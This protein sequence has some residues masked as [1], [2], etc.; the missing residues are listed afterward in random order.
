MNDRVDR[1]VSRAQP[2]TRRQF[3]EATATVGLLGLLKG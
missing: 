3:I 2:L 1:E